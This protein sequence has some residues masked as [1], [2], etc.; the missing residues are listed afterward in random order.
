MAFVWSRVLEL[1]ARGQKDVLARRNGGVWS[2][3]RNEVQWLGAMGKHESRWDDG[4]SVL[5]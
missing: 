5:G 1:S 2:G 4:S 3:P